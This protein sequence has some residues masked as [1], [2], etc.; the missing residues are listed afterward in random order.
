MHSR[1]AAE[2]ENRRQKTLEKVNERKKN[3]EKTV[4]GG[5][6]QREKRRCCWREK[7][8]RRI[9]NGKKEKNKTKTEEQK[10][11]Q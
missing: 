1:E 4:G 6:K 9:R 2:K 8:L 3:P 5:V 10:E 11:K 7:R